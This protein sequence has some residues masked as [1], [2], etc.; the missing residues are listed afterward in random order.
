MNQ[1]SNSDIANPRWNQLYKISG[2]AAL[3]IRNIIPGCMDRP[4]RGS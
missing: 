2:V 4:D 1:R 3:I